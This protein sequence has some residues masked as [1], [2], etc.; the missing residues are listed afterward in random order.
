MNGSF[1][2]ATTGALDMSI[3]ISNRQNITKVDVRRLRRSL[4]RL[5]KW[6]QRDEAEISLLLVDDQQIGILNLNYFQKDRPT[7][8]ISFSMLEGDYGDINPQTIGD[9]VISVETAL[10][11]AADENLQLMDEIEFLTI[12][13]LL[14][15]LGYNH[16]NTSPEEVERM[17]ARERELFFRLRRYAVH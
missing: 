1:L 8:V 10:R 17:V 16:E 2:K 12:H 6:L 13:G 15:L 5:L 4:S 3:S 9:I 7:N 14:H 11:D